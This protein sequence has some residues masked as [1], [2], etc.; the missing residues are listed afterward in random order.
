MVKL[1]KSIILKLALFI[2]K[3]VFLKFDFLISTYSSINKSLN[4]EQGVFVFSKLYKMWDVCICQRYIQPT[5]IIDS[6]DR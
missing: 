4:V 6:S 1:K 2:F 5:F 3:L